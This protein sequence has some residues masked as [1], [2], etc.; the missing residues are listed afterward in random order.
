MQKANDKIIITNEISLQ[1]EDKHIYF[2]FGEIQ[3]DGEFIRLEDEITLVQDQCEVL[4]KESEINV[5]YEGNLEIKDYALR[6]NYPNP[7]LRYS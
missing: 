5:A 7:R 2:G 6:N 4:P 1:Q 3:V